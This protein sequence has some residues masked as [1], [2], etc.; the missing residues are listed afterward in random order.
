MLKGR[1]SC[2]GRCRYDSIAGMK[3]R[4][5]HNGRQ[6][7]IETDEW[8]LITIKR[9]VV[10]SSLCADICTCVIVR[11]RRLMHGRD[12]FPLINTFTLIGEFAVTWLLDRANLIAF[13]CRPISFGPS[14]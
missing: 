6:E 12:A 3:V 8:C 7:S 13:R 2:N 5:H 11:I 14:I 9:E 10:A 1:K 4:Q